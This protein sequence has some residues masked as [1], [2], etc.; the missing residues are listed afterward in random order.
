MPP[1][2]SQGKLKKCQKACERCRSMK[3]KCSGI[4]PCTRCARRNKPCHFPV[5]ELRISVSERYLRELE[6]QISR[7]EN[8]RRR[9]S[10]APLGHS[11]QDG[12]LPGDE[13]ADIPL[14]PQESS[15]PRDTPAHTGW[16]S[17]QNGTGQSLHTPETPRRRDEIDKEVEQD[18]HRSR[19]SRNPLV[20][21][22]PSFAQTPDGRLWYMGPSS[23]WSFCRRV[24]ALIGRKLPE[25]NSLPDPLHVDGMAYRLTWRP[26]PLDEVPDVTNLP[27]LDYAL[28]L[29]RTVQYY[30][31]CLSFMFDEHDYL[32]NLHEFYRDP[33][34]I[35]ATKRSWY[36]QYLLVLAFGKAFLTQRSPSGTPP[37]HQYASRAMA[38]L[39]SLSGDD[40]DPLGGIQAL[41][42]AAVYL[43]SIDM[44]C[45]AFQHIGQALRGC[46]LEGIHRHVPEEMGGPD[47]SKR[48]RT[49]F[50]VVYL[51]DREFSALVGAPSSIR[52]DDIT[53]KLP[54]EMD[55]SV[56]HVNLTLHVRLSRLMATIMTTVYGVGNYFNDTLVRSTQS[57][58][59]SM[60]ELSHDLTEFLN[61]Y[62]HGLI[63]RASKMAIRLML[64][65]HHCVVLTTR[66]LVMCALHMHIE[67][68]ERTQRQTSQIIGLAP[69][70]ASLLQCCADSAQ[71]ILQTLRTLADDDLMD[72]F[73]P[74]QI[75]AAFSAGFVLYLMHSITPSLILSDTWCDNLECVLDK[76][77]AKGNLAAP[78]R[79]LE[80][81]QL[82]ELLAP[83]TP[84]LANDSLPP[85]P[86]QDEN[87]IGEQ[88]YSFDQE[89]FEWDML[90]LKSTVSLPP[91]ELWDL[92]DQLDVDGI[93][94][95]VGV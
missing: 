67:H 17:M 91:Q 22:D 28:F 12:T 93:L 51:L 80:L 5:E 46:I 70:V 49:I 86:L 9:G 95:S 42:L 76:L 71:T 26:S 43:Q 11:V 59:Y 6:G 60:A 29:F 66:P 47:L 41:S 50:W 23:S 62:F 84:T 68:I 94:Q 25:S 75:E 13:D 36:C 30:F 54:A 90:A 78:L 40:K 38:L 52:D 14:T 8:S 83:L 79:K 72:A 24:L 19:F 15:I 82:K 27:P 64:A 31:G 58:I 2:S 3:V 21:E 63:S 87:E 44:R 45:A 32:R 18:T 37:G 85:A 56:E 1:A 74:F 39:P 10:V 69:P 33:P 53:V 65:H 81:R 61:T 16:R 34:A 7:S 20:D 73:L 77:I 4:S 57:V 89:E 88:S 35:A 48:C 92:A 55:N